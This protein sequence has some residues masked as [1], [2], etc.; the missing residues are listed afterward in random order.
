M[1]GHVLSPNNCPLHG[2]SGPRLIHASLGSPE[3][4]TQMASRSVQPFLHRSSQSV[5]ILY[6]EPC[7]GPNRVLNPN[8]I[9]IGSAV[10][11]GLTTV[12][13]TLTD[14]AIQ[15]V[16]I[17]RMYIRNTAMRPHNTSQVNLT[18]LSDTAS[19]LLTKVDTRCVKFA[20]VQLN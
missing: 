14:H 10:F 16:T 1:P 4:I 8:S 18:T 20:T 9:L 6:N 19:L 15:S 11:A 2:Q 5:A 17:G 12:T 3:S 13:D 7:L